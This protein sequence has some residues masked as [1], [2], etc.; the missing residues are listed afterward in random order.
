[1]HSADPSGRSLAEIAGS[2]NAG[3][4]DICLSDWCVLLVRDL[5]DGP[6]TRHVESYW[7]WCVWV[8]SRN[9]RTFIYLWEYAKFDVNIGDT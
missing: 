6:I 3:G 7:T 8:W 4:I 1:M 9:L 5:S 2:N